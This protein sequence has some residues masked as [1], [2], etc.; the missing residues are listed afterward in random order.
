[1]TGRQNFATDLTITRACTR[2][3]WL[4]PRGT[5]MTKSTRSNLR[6]DVRSRFDWTTMPAQAQLRLS[7]VNVGAKARQPQG[8]YR[9]F[10]KGTAPGRG[11]AT[12]RGHKGEMQL[13]RISPNIAMHYDLAGENPPRVTVN[14][15]STSLRLNGGRCCD[16]QQIDNFIIYVI[17]IVGQPRVPLGWTFANLPKIRF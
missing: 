14:R 7:S 10:E 3:K 8:R 13:A 6:G 2:T 4:S 9:L 1:M 11:L 5:K 16:D 15:S 12:G 17:S